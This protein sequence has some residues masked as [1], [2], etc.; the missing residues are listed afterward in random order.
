MQKCRNID[1]L[2][3]ITVSADYRWNKDDSRQLMMHSI[4]VYPA[5]FPPMIAAEAFKYA[6]EEG[7]NTHSVADYF[8]GCG[9]VALESKK[10]GLPFWGCDINPVA[11]LIAK[12]KTFHY[13]IEKLREYYMEIRE[14]CDRIRLSNIYEDCYSA[15]TERMKY[16]FSEKTYKELYCLKTAIENIDDT[17]AYLSAFQCIFSSILKNASKWLQ[18]SIKPQID[19]KKKEADVGKLFAYQSE[20]FIKAAEEVNRTIDTDTVVDIQHRDFLSVFSAK[21]SDLLITSP[22]YV[23]SYEYADLHQLSSIWLGYADDYRTLRKGSI[24]SSYQ[25]QNVQLETLPLNTT[26]KSIVKKL[27]ELEVAPAKI[28][29]IGRYYSNMEQVV[30]KSTTLINSNGMAIFVI[31]DSEYKGVK[32]LNSKH[33]IEAMMEYGYSDIKIGKRTIEKC[34]C[35]PFR[36]KS[37]K[38]TSKTTSTSEIYH[39]EFVISG[40]IR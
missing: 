33:L 24:G 36:D 15:A 22:P 1:E 6:E 2:N 31:G 4:H 21:K 5:K 39:E 32:L 13:D 26:G 28:K 3:N 19:P 12:S 11:V 20:R 29:A 30:R 23:T 10:R 17:E 14:N 34:M 38:F 18:K 37:G 25:C 8:C 7:V 16:W 27:M 35:V 9:T 40:R